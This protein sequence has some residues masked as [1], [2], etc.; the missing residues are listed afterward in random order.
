MNTNYTT[1]L[2]RLHAAAPDLLE[3]LK[4]L[5]DGLDAHH[6]RLSIDAPFGPPIDKAR[7]AIAKAEGRA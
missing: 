6:K 1:D 7:A 5:L 3:A 2:D 4:S